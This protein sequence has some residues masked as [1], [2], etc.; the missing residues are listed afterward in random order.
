MKD[1]DSIADLQPASYNPREIS[2]EAASGLRASMQR[3]GD[4]A[5]ITWNRKTGTLVCGH[6]RVRQLTE[7]GAQ[8]RHYD[9]GRPYLQLPGGDVY[10]VRVVSWDLGDEM[11]ANLSANNEHIGGRF[12]A[13]A[14]EV[15]CD[16]KDIIG[17]VAFNE[18]QLPSLEEQVAAFDEAHG[19]S[20][21]VEQDEVPEPPAEPMTKVGDV[22]TL[23][24]HTLVCGD[25]CVPA[26][27]D[28]CDL[29]LT[30]PPYC[31]G[32]EIESGSESRYVHDDDDPDAWLSMLAEAT[33]LALR[34]ANVAFFNLQMLQ[35]NK[36][37]LVEWMHAYRQSLKDVIIWDKGHAAPAMSPCV[38]NS[39]FEFLF[40]LSARC[41]KRKFDSAQFHGT[42]DNVF[43]SGKSSGTDG[44][45]H[46]AAFP[47]AL[48]SFII[49]TFAPK[50]ARVMDPF[51]GTGT[52]IVAAEQLGCSCA[53]VELEPS[54][55]DVTVERWQQLTG[56]KATR[57]SA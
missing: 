14:S 22:W 16:V 55:C 6:Q 46:K 45:H 50:N 35:P 12:T 9:N 43:S 34:H 13:E 53:G 40:A 29:L 30:S 8:L 25:A 51:C 28:D 54:Y 31:A 27:Y 32:R 23:G 17:D 52:T 4:I 26:H 38:T 7:L 41:Q 3:F 56:G 33:E 48:P 5:G 36:V 37:R 11:A 24:R 19:D 42:V 2:D 57:R 21:D 39:R 47:V 44:V 15:L 20:G 1:L 18:L 10:Q 49:R